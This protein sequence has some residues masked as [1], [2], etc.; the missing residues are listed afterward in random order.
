MKNELSYQD[1]NITGVIFLKNSGH[2]TEFSLKISSQLPVVVSTTCCFQVIMNGKNGSGNLTQNLALLDEKPQMGIQV[3]SIMSYAYMKQQN[4]CFHK[5]EKITNHHALIAKIYI[6]QEV[7]KAPTFSVFR[8]Q[9]KHVLA[10]KPHKTRHPE[11][12]QHQQGEEKESTRDPRQ[13][14]KRNN[15]QSRRT[16][17]TEIEGGRGRRGRP[18]S[19]RYRKTR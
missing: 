1:I 3:T 6:E 17:K 5:H 4:N 11:L 7:S 2:Q 12:W 8:T 15:D 9:R 16:K 10:K 18:D 14:G 19:W 13:Q